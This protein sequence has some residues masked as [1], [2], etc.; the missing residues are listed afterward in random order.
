M[1]Y[2]K[3]PIIIEAYKIGSDEKKPEWVDEDMLEDV[4]KR[5]QGRGY[6]VKDQYGT[7]NIWYSDSNINDMFTPLDRAVLGLGIL[8]NEERWGTLSFSHCGKDREGV[9]IKA[10][11]YLYPYDETIEGPKEGSYGIEVMDVVGG[12]VFWTRGG[13]SPSHMYTHKAPKNSQ[14]VRKV[15]E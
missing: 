15:V 13:C 7:S 2:V 14:K 5:Y 11:E 3:N 4:T 6:L 10:G 9:P 1:K 8:D 12:T